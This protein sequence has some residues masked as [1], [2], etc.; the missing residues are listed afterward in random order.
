MAFVDRIKYDAP[1]DEAIAWKYPS[2]AIRLGSQLIVHQSQEAVLFRGGQALDTF[3]PGTHTLR[4]GNL[5][6][7]ARL[8][9]LPFGGLTPF[10]AEVWFVNRTVKRDL[11]WGTPGPIQVVDPT[12][13]VPVS[14]RAFGRWGFRVRDA[15]S[16]LTQIVG[17]QVATDGADYVA[18]D[19]VAAYFA[20]E[21]GQRLTDALAR[22]FVERAVSVFEVGARLNELSTFVAGDVARE[23]DRFGIEVVNVNV[24]RASI[25][26][27]EQARF[28]EILARRME[29]EQISQATVGPAY[30][31][32]RTFDTLEK[33]AENEGGA[34]GQ[35]LG[36]GLGLG[37][38]I[39]S[40]VPI[41]QKVGGALQVEPGTAEPGTAEPAVLEER[42]RVLKRMLD[43]G[44][45]AQEDYDRKKRAVLDEL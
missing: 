9:G 15:R 27:E 16:F 23:L 26:D 44:L 10:T 25:P 31:T 33:A 24:E 29:I 13:R 34:A 21:I 32:M 28:Q 8:V 11:G 37:V 35:L 22:Y 5:P 7:L 40:G 18:A 36:A 19:R 30:A 1:S 6:L 42:L 2:E 3:G 20:G 17:T 39:G 14:V 38:G 4:T 41:G 45:I 43:D 12:Y